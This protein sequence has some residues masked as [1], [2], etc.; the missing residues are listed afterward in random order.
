MFFH[1]F[2]S[3]LLAVK[4]LRGSNCED[5][6]QLGFAGFFSIIKLGCESATLRQG[7][8]KWQG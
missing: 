3:F 2:K 7:C 6:S 4:N 1:D 5:V 8:K